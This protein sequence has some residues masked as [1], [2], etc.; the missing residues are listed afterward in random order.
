MPDL[1]A[2]PAGL[3]RQRAQQEL[4]SAAQPLPD[5]LYWQ[6]SPE[7]RVDLSS[8]LVNR[9][10]ECPASALADADDEF[11]W[12]AGLAARRLATVVLAELAERD[13]HPGA[14]LAEVVERLAH[15]EDGSLGQ[16]L[17]TLPP[18][19]RVAV[20]RAASS[21]LVSARN[22]MSRWPPDAAFDPPPLRW[23]VLGRPV[24]VSANATLV[25]HALGRMDR[26]GL[27]LGGTPTPARSAHEAGHLALAATLVHGLVPRSVVLL[28]P[29]TGQR[30]VT[31]VSDGLLAES[32]TR[33]ADALAQVV[34][35]REGVAAE[36]RPGRHCD[37]CS[38]RA[39][40]PVAATPVPW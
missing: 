33:A 29:A 11:H 30:E 25:S 31:E 35:H 27:L 16:W 38:I 22:L 8:F 4:A 5:S 37:H 14:M 6:T 1:A 34:G 36:R 17:A 23:T 20:M 15:Q 32:L 10:T 21:P 3:W 24:A 2:A 39:D 18:G 12:T 26:L 28:W 9:L 40:C 13:A 7:L 19:G